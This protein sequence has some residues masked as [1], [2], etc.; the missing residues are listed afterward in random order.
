MVVLVI[1]V[2][3]GYFQGNS[4]IIHLLGGDDIDVVLM[5]ERSNR[6]MENTDSAATAS[7][8]YLPPLPKYSHLDEEDELQLNN[9][10]L[11]DADTT[12]VDALLL[13]QQPLRDTLSVTR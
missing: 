8:N 2:V 5:E 7:K 9:M 4:A 13:N 10:S 11:D 12:M 3:V 6:S 1:I